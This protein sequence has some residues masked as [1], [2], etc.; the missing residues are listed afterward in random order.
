MTVL[1]RSSKVKIWTLVCAVLI[2]QANAEVTL[3]ASVP[4]PSKSPAAV[5]TPDAQRLLNEMQAAYAHLGSLSETIEEYEPTSDSASLNAVGVA[6]GIPHPHPWEKLNTLVLKFKKPNLLSLR[7]AGIEEDIRSLSAYI[8]NESLVSDGREVHVVSVGSNNLWDNFTEPSQPQL[9]FKLADEKLSGLRFWPDFLSPLA[10]NKTP[11]ELVGFGDVKVISI[12]VEH[13]TM[14]DG[15]AVDVIVARTRHTSLTDSPESELAVLMLGS[16][17]HL[18]REL[19]TGT[20]YGKHLYTTSHLKANPRFHQSD[21]KFVHPADPTPP[22][23]RK[24]VDAIGRAYQSLKTLSATMHMESNDYETNFKR[25]AVTTSLLV[26]KPKFV[27]NTV[28]AN[29]KTIRVVYDGA[30]LYGYDPSRP[31]TYHILNTREDFETGGTI[32]EELGPG[33][34]GGNDPFLFRSMRKWFR[35]SPAVQNGTANGIPVVILK[36]LYFGPWVRPTTELW[37]FGRADHFLRSMDLR[38]TGPPITQLNLPRELWSPYDCSSHGEN[39]LNVYRLTYSHMKVNIP[40]KRQS[41]S[42]HG[43]PRS[44]GRSQSGLVVF[45]WRALGKVSGS[46]TEPFSAH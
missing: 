38:N 20:P 28:T 13:P 37:I 15:E 39:G 3:G 6:H 2:G 8:P 9:L 22:A 10:V 41:V 29:G 26:K 1:S 32:G 34:F 46:G 18:L 11:L 5:I 27:S 23:V 7:V 24:E 45:R 33:M 25:E 43:T 17:D 12:T 36:A 31:Q 44:A 4:T 42:L 30:N 21:F 35:F 19:L 14:R 16:R 40:L